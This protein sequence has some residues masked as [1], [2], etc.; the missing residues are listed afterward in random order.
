MSIKLPK[1][2]FIIGTI[3]V[4]E[5]TYMFSPKVLDRAN[6]IEFKVTEADMNIFLENH[7][8]VDID[9][10][11]GKAADMALSFVEDAK[12]KTTQKDKE[13]AKVLLNFF[14]TL[15]EVN[16][17]FGYRT[18]NE[19]YRFISY[20][21]KLGMTDDDAVDS[22]IIQKLLPKLHGSRKHLNEP[23]KKLWELCL[24]PDVNLLLTEDCVADSK[25]CKYLLSADKI[26][27]MYKAAVNNGF[28]S[29]A[30][31][32]AWLM[33]LKYHLEQAKALMTFWN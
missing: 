23:L 13:I 29:F 22:A 17:E 14:K 16:A 7:I 25:T 21:K 10:S 9:L 24:N 26:L 15:K 4:D 20:A 11:N 32:Y 2:L 5:T 27:R 31:A 19:I 12:D 8:A 33:S 3:N 1:N 28:T 30:E 6:V 18:A